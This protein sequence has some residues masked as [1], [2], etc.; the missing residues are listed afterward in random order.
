[1][2][3]LRNF[4]PLLLLSVIGRSESFVPRPA[5][6]PSLVAVNGVPFFADEVGDSAVANAD[7]APKDAAPPADVTLTTASGDSASIL[8]AAEFMVN[9]F[10][11]QSPQNLVVDGDDPSSISDGA[12]SSL[13]EEQQDD[14]TSKYGEI[15]GVRT[16]QSGLVT[17]AVGEGLL[18]LV[19]VEAALLDRNSMQVLVAERSE[20]MLKNAV[21]S[22][23]PKQRREYK[24]SPA[25]DVVD[26]LLPSNLDLVVVLS[27]LSVSPRARRRG[28]A[29]SLCREAERMA[30]EDW[31]FDEIC[32]KVEEGNDA[33]RS[34]YEKKLGYEKV[35][36]NPAI[37]LRVDVKNG[38]FEEVPA[39]TLLLTKKL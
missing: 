21:A 35:A 4:Y 28:V 33:A 6:V 17:A 2:S 14:L 20:A 5:L 22:L 26:Q 9:S 25:S 7:E 18:G 30:K 1:M 11:L 12:R 29:M 24:N 32:L 34:L 3:G 37:G 13:I 23:G 31:T 16:L 8:E 27:N 10:W 15:M 38:K 19:G 39:E 36:S